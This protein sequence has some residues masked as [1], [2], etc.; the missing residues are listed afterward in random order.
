VVFDTS[1]TL[2]TYRVEEPDDLLAVLR[3]YAE[4]DTSDIFWG[5]TVGTYRPLYHSESLGFHGQDSPPQTMR[6]RETAAEAMR[7]LARRGVD[8]LRHA[9]GFAHANGLRIWA[10][11]RIS[12]NHEH[13]FSPDYPG[14]RFL[15]VNGDKRVLDKGG[16]PHHQVTMSFAYPEIRAMAVRSLLEQAR[17][18]VDGLYIDFCRKYPLVGWEPV[19]VEAFKRQTGKDPFVLPQAEWQ[20]DWIAHTCG[21]VTQFLRELRASLAA[22]EKRRGRRIPIAAQV[23]G[24]WR[25]PLGVPAA[26]LDAMD[27]LTWAREGLVDIVAPSEWTALML[28]TQCF[29]RMAPLLEGTGC[30]LWGAIGP[31]FREAL[32][33]IEERAAFDGALA[34][35]DPWRFMATAHDYYS[36]GADGVY[37]WEAHDLASVPQ[38]WNV[39]RR[40]G[41]RDFLRRTFGDKLG[42]FD[43]SHWIE[44][45]PLKIPGEGSQ[46]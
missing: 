6:H 36:Q 24:G 21:Y 12:K 27:L 30:E 41:D 42:R 15:T 39:I 33:T 10:N 3:P 45:T 18:G 1:M 11:Y 14:G 19:V 37:L 5:T 29:D 32:G 7:A 20:H 23:P 28:E 44:Q 17:Y 25:F 35:T 40:M 16:S 8:P 43:G 38:V 46:A 26:M 2:S 22:E 34:D 13:D 31:H 9:I 4:S